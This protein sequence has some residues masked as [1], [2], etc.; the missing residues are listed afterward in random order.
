MLFKRPITEILVFETKAS[1][2]HSS[3]VYLKFILFG[4][5]QDVV[6]KDFL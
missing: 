2:M 6:I 3:V 1:V 4:E 5:Y